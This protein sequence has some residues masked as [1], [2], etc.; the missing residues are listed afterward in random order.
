MAVCREEG[1]SSGLAFASAN[2]SPP[3][4]T[5]YNA[6]FRQYLC[7]LQREQPEIFSEEEDVTRYGISRTPRRSAVTRAGQVGLS[8]LVVESVNRWRTVESAKAARP[9]LSMK[10]HYTAMP[11]V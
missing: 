6:F 7:R 10:M 9:K 8:T 11:G 5:D 3:C 4:S 1:R 2:G